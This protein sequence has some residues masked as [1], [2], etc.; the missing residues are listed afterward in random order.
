MRGKVVTIAS[1]KCTVDTQQGAYECDARRRLID[2]DTGESKPLTVGDDVEFDPT[3][4]A[5]GVVTRVL[6]RRTRL[7]RARVRGGA[8]D[9]RVEHVI[10]ANVDQLLIVCSV[11]EPPFTVGII[12]RYIIAGD[13]GGLEPAICINKIDFAEAPAEYEDI[14]ALYRGLDFPVVATST[15]AGSGIQELRALLAGKST[16]FAGHSGVGK[17]SLLNALQP[18]LELKTGSVGVWKGQHCT[19]RVSLLKLD[20]GGYVVDTPGI[21]EFSLWDIERSDVAQFFP[22][23]WD[24]SHE[25]RLPDCAHTHE[26]GCAVKAA[27]ERGELPLMRYESY[28]GILESIE[29]PE[30][31]RESDVDRPEEQIVKKKRRPSRRALKERRR[32]RWDEEL[33]EA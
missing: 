18:G 22:A 13:A 14:A 11:R 33:D 2:S 27:L 16:V 28:V 25:C 19:E 29:A 15:V 17:S 12:D 30:A 4:P 7:S 8:D 26:P 31:P 1:V 3:G 32:M 21:R 24:L 10:V 20:G 23:I 5:E 6:P 9:R